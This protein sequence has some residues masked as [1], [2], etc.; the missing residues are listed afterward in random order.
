[1][2]VTMNGLGTIIGGHWRGALPLGLSLAGPLIGAHIVLA[3]LLFLLRGAGSGL[4]AVLVVV[5]GAVLIW[6]VVGGFRAAD[7]SLRDPDG[8]Q[9]AALYYAVIFGLVGSSLYQVAGILAAS[10]IVTA[11]IDPAPSSLTA[12][13]EIIRLDGDI[14]LRT[15]NAMAQML[16]GTHP[17]RT[18]V[19]TS[20]GGNIHAAR[21][22]ARLVSDADLQTIAEGRCYSACTLIFVAGIRRN[23]GQGGSL[24][25]HQYHLADFEDRGAGLYPDARAE[26]QRDRR[27][28]AARG[29]AGP[30]IDRMYETE[31]GAIWQPSRSELLTAR[32]L[33]E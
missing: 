18:L 27:Y 6:Q 21:G 10:H 31:H 8:A 13:G 20:D 29:I 32:V 11:R 24:G 4:V 5:Q 7:R 19:L 1:M 33:T 30:F 17:Y 26:Q 15:Y 12:D 16:A 28:F 9:F 14:T 2:L 22:L 23:L 3:G 25:F